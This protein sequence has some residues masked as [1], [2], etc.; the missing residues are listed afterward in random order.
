M[1]KIIALALASVMLACMTLCVFAN[2]GGFVDSVSINQ[3]PELIGGGNLSEE[4]LAEL[5]ITA[6]ANRDQLPED[7]RLQIEEA[8]RL[9]LENKDLSVLNAKLKDYADELGVE[10]TA[11]AV[12]D[13]FDIHY[14]NCDDHKGHGY[15]NIQLKADTLENFVCLLHYYNGEFTVVE[16]AKVTNNGENLEFTASEFSPF[17]IVVNTGESSDAPQTNDLLPI[18]MA[19][20]VISGLMII[21]LAVAYKKER[22]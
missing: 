15:F 8:Y 22:A 2:N 16:D 11:L 19:V 9:I 6:F 1:R 7:L 10:V 13:L 14:I 5:V 20:A 12:S 3:A 18:Y 4:C 21:G 17:I